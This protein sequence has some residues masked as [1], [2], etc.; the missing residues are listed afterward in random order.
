MN[1]SKYSS[2]F[3]KVEKKWLNIW[4]DKLTKA[5]EKNTQFVSKIHFT[6]LVKYFG[7]IK[8]YFREISLKCCNQ[9]NCGRWEL[10]VCASIVCWAEAI[11]R[12]ELQ[13]GFNPQRQTTFENIYIAVTKCIFHF[14]V[15]LF[16]SISIA[17]LLYKDMAPITFDPIKGFLKI[18]FLKCEKF[19]F[20]Q[21]LF[22]K[23]SPENV[24]GVEQCRW[25]FMIAAIHVG[26]E[27][28]AQLCD[29]LDC[30]DGRPGRNTAN[31]GGEILWIA[32]EKY[33][34]AEG[35]HFHS[36]ISLKA[37]PCSSKKPH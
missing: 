35:H 36:A 5:T 24:I 13:N 34:G 19:F 17:F 20:S 10:V 32:V 27:R 14:F 29:R 8:I 33:C 21:Q 4:S 2:S 12:I 37:F 31:S 22:S 28:M 1:T 25:I 6:Q 7:R 9:T 26:G 3:L 18:S 23:F 11:V 15:T 30:S 16:I